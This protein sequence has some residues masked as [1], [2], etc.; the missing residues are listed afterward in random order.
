MAWNMDLEGCMLDMGFSVSNNS[1][2]P[3]T[4]GN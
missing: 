2:N 3:E 1:V 4:T